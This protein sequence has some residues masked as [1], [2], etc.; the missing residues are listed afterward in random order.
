MHRRSFPLHQLDM[1]KR[2]VPVLFPQSVSI[3][4]LHL[5]PNFSVKDN[6]LNKREPQMMA[7]AVFN[8]IAKLRSTVTPER[9]SLRILKSQ[10][11][12]NMNNINFFTVSL[13]CLERLF[14]TLSD[15]AAQPITT[16]IPA[17]K[18]F[19]KDDIPRK[20]KVIR[21]KA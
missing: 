2:S 13:S 5:E 18:M 14:E 15:Q 3:C 21:S 9:I 16:P 19:M 10:S 7:K 1:T 11:E 6:D 4:R 12:R 8:E 20:R 17:L